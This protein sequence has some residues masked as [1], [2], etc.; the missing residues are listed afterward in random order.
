MERQEK[1]DKLVTLVK[2]TDTGSNFIWQEKTVR[3][4]TT[5]NIPQ[6]IYFIY[7]R[8]DLCNDE[9]EHTNKTRKCVICIESHIMQ[10]RDVVSE[11][12]QS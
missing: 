11:K 6:L 2:R 1:R 3:N 7:I 4:I 8:I 12:I 9:N 10:L 5:D